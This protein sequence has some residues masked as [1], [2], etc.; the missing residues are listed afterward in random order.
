MLSQEDRSNGF[1]MFVP[2]I[3]AKHF[4]LNQLSSAFKI[5]LVEPIVIS[6]RILIILDSGQP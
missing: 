2:Q 3:R 6:Q 4:A 5:E 1:S